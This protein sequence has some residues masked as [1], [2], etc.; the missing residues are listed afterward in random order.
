MAN[1]TFD[2]KL[3]DH[4]LSDEHLQVADTMI[5]Y[6]IAELVQNQ[7]AVL[8]QTSRLMLPLFT[9]PYALNHYTY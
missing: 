5:K 3:L 8:E 6:C 7:Q 4:V 1:I 9:S 2:I